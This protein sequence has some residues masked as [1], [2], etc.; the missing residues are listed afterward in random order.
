MIYNAAEKKEIRAEFM[1]IAN[2]HQSSVLRFID[3]E[4]LA[5][6]DKAQKNNWD[7]IKA[8]AELRK[9]LKKAGAQ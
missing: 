8:L 6:M 7:G 3:T 1:G 9:F 2:E 4:C 5:L